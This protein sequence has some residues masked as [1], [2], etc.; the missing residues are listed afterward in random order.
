MKRLQSKIFR[1]KYSSK[2]SVHHKNIEKE[3]EE[4]RKEINELK[5]KKGKKHHIHAKKLHTR[6][7]LLHT[8]AI[9]H[10]HPHLKDDIKNMVS[11][12][13]D[14]VSAGAKFIGVKSVEASKKLREKISS[15]KKSANTNSEKVTESKVDTTPKTESVTWNDNEKYW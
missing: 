10:D 12:L 4:L 2:K 1:D 9:R 7:K 11:G 5:H 3:Y 13:G 14:L 15:D 6:A 8:K